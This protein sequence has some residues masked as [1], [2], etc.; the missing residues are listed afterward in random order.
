MAN[1]LPGWQRSESQY[2]FVKLVIIAYPGPVGILMN[3]Y[4]PL[5]CQCI[6]EIARYYYIIVFGEVCV[7]FGGNMASP[8]VGLPI[9][10]KDWGQEPQ[11]GIIYA[12]NCHKEV[13]RGM[14][15]GGNHIDV[16]KCKRGMRAGYAQCRGWTEYAY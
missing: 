15:T 2:Q 3:S 6:F 10:W 5:I 11:F 12:P 14:A 9:Q 1:K 4:C 8:G 13:K 16:A 7:V